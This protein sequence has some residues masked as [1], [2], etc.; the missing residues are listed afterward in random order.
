M[1]V[2]RA[3]NTT[4]G[5]DTVP[6]LR[7][8]WER[9]EEL[10][11][12]GEGSY[13]RAILVRNRSTGRKCVIKQIKILGMT[14]KEKEEVKAE[15]RILASLDHPNIIK[16]MDDSFIESGSLHIVTEYA[17]KGDLYHLITRQ[18]SQPGVKHY[19]PEQMILNWFIQ[20]TMA[21]KHIHD[22]HILHRDLKS[23]NVFLTSQGIVKLGDFGI[24]KVLTTTTEFCQTM[25]GTPY[26]MSP[27]L[28]ED[29][30]YD[31]KS[32]VWS[33]GC[34][35][36]EMCSLKHAFNG[37]SLPA[38]ILKI[39][40]G[41]YPPIPKVYSDQMRRLVERLLSTKPTNRP[42]V[43]EILALPF[44]KQSIKD[45]VAFNISRGTSVSDRSGRLSGSPNAR[46]RS[47]NNAPSQR[48]SLGGGSSRPHSAN[49]D[50]VSSHKDYGRASSRANS[51]SNNST[52]ESSYARNKPK[53][54]SSPSSGSQYGYKGSSAQST[55]A[56]TQNERTP[57]SNVV[58]RARAAL[59]NVARPK[60][61]P[62]PVDMYPRRQSSGGSEDSHDNRRT[63][64]T[65]SSATRVPSRRRLPSA[66]SNNAQPSSTKETASLRRAT[67]ASSAAPTTSKIKTSPSSSIGRSTPP[68]SEEEKP[69]HKKKTPPKDTDKQ[70]QEPSSGKRFDPSRTVTISSGQ[71]EAAKPEDP[72]PS[73]KGSVEV[74]FY[75]KD[76]ITVTEVPEA[77]APS[78]TASTPRQT[79]SAKAIR[80]KIR[81]DKRANK[82]NTKDW[83]FVLP[84]Q[85]PQ[86]T[87]DEDNTSS[88]GSEATD[89]SSPGYPAAAPADVNTVEAATRALSSRVERLRGACVQRLGEKL[90]TEVYVFLSQRSSGEDDG[91]EDEE[92]LSR[93]L[94][95]YDNWREIARSI[96][97]LIF[98]EDALA[99]ASVATGDSE[100]TIC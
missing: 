4:P 79:P 9:Y 98:C 40:R 73:R 60:T 53:T 54:T 17:D 45:I 48:K 85:A 55:P 27:E 8:V 2:T 94:K 78:P 66:P 6:E 44:I 63:E 74:A 21:V 38:L 77:R 7:S 65:S 91:L 58:S 31:Q 47:S 57:Q 56:A 84:N 13:G 15:A 71:D 93:I 70:K 52:P 46:P 32:D 95:G 22:R 62:G 12:I 67:S 43:A 34:L 72:K 76:G 49:S 86:P 18:A 69:S 89:A 26:N 1:A 29:K 82:N 35:L 81:E 37:K 28:C 75:G 5:L 80:E 90:F 19:F 97:Q 39:M 50:R 68:V 99:S 51:S 16:L 36:Y 20:V 64:H 24:A 42:M 3:I 61:R 23:Q 11:E 96:A 14:D 33:L 87:H 10:K 88:V 92:S 59:G 83:E 30:P 25:V 100:I 41:R